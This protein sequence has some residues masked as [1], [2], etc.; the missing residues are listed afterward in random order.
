[1]LYIR[2]KRRCR[3]FSRRRKEENVFAD[4][5]KIISVQFV[6]ER[7]NFF[8]LLFW[9]ESRE[10]VEKWNNKFFWPLLRSVFLLNRWS[11]RCILLNF[12]R[13]VVLSVRFTYS[14]SKVAACGLTNSFLLSFVRSFHW[15]VIKTNNTRALLKIRSTTTTTS[16]D[17][18]TDRSFVCWRRRRWQLWWWFDFF[19]KT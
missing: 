5:F 17:W 14:Y 19:R 16:I 4:G 2:I 13:K 10:T 1:M 11:F 6:V 7:H 3:G 8:L 9:L 15:V 18:L 12:C